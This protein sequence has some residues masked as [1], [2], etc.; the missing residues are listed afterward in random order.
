[1][2][3]RCRQ[4]ALFA[5][6]LC[7]AGC[8]S[9]DIVNGLTNSG[10]Y[11]R[12][13][14]LRYRDGERGALDVYRPR[15]AVGPLPVVVFFYGGG[16]REGQRE[17]YEFVASELT[18]AGYIVVIPDYRLH[19]DVQFPAFV[20]DA[21][22]AVAW[23]GNHIDSF[24]GDPARIAVAGHS[25]GAHIAA[26]LALDTR[27][28]DAAGADA[29]RVAAWIGL[30]GPYDFLPLD[31]GYLTEVFPEDSRP[32]S[33]PI[34]YARADAPPTLLIHGGDDDTVWPRNSERM[35]A[36]LADLGV[37]VTLHLYPDVGHARVVAA[38]ASPFDGL[39]P[40]ARDIIGFLDGLPAFSGSPGTPAARTGSPAA[41]RSTDSRSRSL[42]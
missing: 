23:V 6:A 30:S 28:L 42:R 21:A 35:A 17:D 24:G 22:L 27:Y 40:T 16:W 41:R 15:S 2:L 34:R 10:H 37:P 39:A 38:L 32:Q 29:A 26:L 18:R 19:P 25:A 7:L 1:M 8:S 3:P 13:A 4:I 14:D 36:R 11:L 9:F 31:P 12:D 20:E 5:A 33:Q